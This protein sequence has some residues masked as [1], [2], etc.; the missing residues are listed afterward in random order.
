[1]S[2]A[3]STAGAAAAAALLIFSSAVHA[4]APRHALSLYGAPKY[5][6]GFTHFDYANPE[7]PKGGAIRLAAVGTYDNLNPFTLKGVAAIGLGRVF[8]TL[9]VSSSDEAFTE[10]GLIAQ[11]MEIADDRRSVTF[12]LHP[13][14]RFHD[15]SPITADD[16][17][18]TFATLKA[19]GHPFYRAY[20]ASVI[21]AERL[22]PRKVRFVFDSGGNRELP[23][24]IGQLPVLSKAWWST[25]HFGKTTLEPPLGSGP[26]R[27]ATLE[28]GRSITYR[29]VR[30]YWAKDL[31]VNRGRFNFNSIR[32][33]YY[34]DA[35][36]ALEAFKAGAYDFRQENSSKAWATGYDG[37]ALRSGDIRKVAI[38]NQR[39]TGM[40]AFV[41]NTRRPI[42][43]DRRVRQALAFAFDFEWT[44]KN[45]FYGAYTRTRSFFSNSELASRGLP[46]AAEK[47]ILAPYRARIPAQVFNK[48]YMPPRTDGRG[49]IRANLRQATRLLKQ[50]GWV[51]RNG[52]RVQAGSG[53]P[54]VFEIMLVSP[55]FERVVLPFTRNLARLGI[56]AEVRTVDPAQYQKRLDD[57]DFDM[58]ITTFG[59]SLSPGNEQRDFW[60]SKAAATPGSR[61]FAGVRDP[62]V[63]ALVDELI[64]APDRASLVAHARALD[65]VLLWGFYVIP[66]W[67]VRS[68]RVAYW[69]FFA[70]PALNPP[71]AL[72]FDTWWVDA[73]RLGRIR[74]QQN[75]R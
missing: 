72:G 49:D 12:T 27:V 28:P 45:L 73:A 26:Y 74:K 10:Y 53:A 41:Y 17:T 32:Y 9:T 21:R 61:N 68:F 24:I 25:R 39:P 23:L 54:F 52:K 42:F 59:Q 22:G 38:P 34:R 58:T 43:A 56:T 1:M 14:A 48:V 62:V 16:V 33:D 69:D 15:G 18:W 75:G 5:P 71:Y 6:A 36:V 46:S 30:D 63:D 8:D 35:T 67:H 64:A 44:N 51:V 40:Q 7:A 4:A 3:L 47:A 20:Y 11:S 65:R 70:R 2:R 29:R 66:Q 50:A 19:R 31:G 55:S 13:E 57:F 60:S 37:P